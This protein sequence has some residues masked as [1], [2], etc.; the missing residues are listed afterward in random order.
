MIRVLYATLLAAGLVASSAHASTVL[1]T[2]TNRG[3][4]LELVKQYAE[5]GWDVIATARNPDNQA[6]AV[7]H[8]RDIMDRMGGFTDVTD[9]R[10]VPGVEVSILVNRAEAARFG[11]DVS[12]LGQAVQLLTQGITVADY[13]PAMW[14][15]HWTFACVSPARNA[16]SRSWQACVCRQLPVWSQS[17]TL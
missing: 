8:I 3:I 5:R 4:G 6:L 12:L 15:D 9:T 16:R 7:Q 2:G 10:P 17:P 14:T 1:V 13:R 11:A